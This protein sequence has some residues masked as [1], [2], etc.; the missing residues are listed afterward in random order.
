[1]PEF[2]VIHF[3][4]LRPFGKTKPHY[5]RLDPLELGPTQSGDAIRSVPF[6]EGLKRGQKAA[7]KVQWRWKG[8]HFKMMPQ[9]QS[10]MQNRHGSVEERV[11][12]LAPLQ[13]LPE[14]HAT[15]ASG[16]E[17]R[18]GQAVR[19]FWPVMRALKE[20]TPERR[21]RCGPF[22]F[23][24]LKGKGQVPLDGTRHPRQW[25]ALLLG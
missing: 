2:G 25:A 6:R 8:T 23:T 18:L 15:A 20:F 3:K 13:R 1:M 12:H 11:I 19:A 21:D 14:E 7:T 16:S 17:P 22:I 9:C 5:L 24:F 10:N 4:Q